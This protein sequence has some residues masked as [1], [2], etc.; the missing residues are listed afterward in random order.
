[1][2]YWILLSRFLNSFCLSVMLCV[3]SPV[4]AISGKSLAGNVC[5]LNLLFPDV[6]AILLSFKF[7]ATSFSSDSAL[8]MSSSFLALTVVSM[9]PSTEDISICVLI[10]ISMS[11]LVNVMFWLFFLIKTL[12]STGKVWRR[13]T[14]PLTI[15][16]GLRSWSLL[17]FNSSII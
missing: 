11:V 14:I 13:S 17:H 4:L 15:E 5:K 12:A 7:K 1:M 2:A 16:S 3:N 8:R 10:W 9:S 6:M